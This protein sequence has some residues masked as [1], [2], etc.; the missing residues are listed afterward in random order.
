[1]ERN[2]NGIRVELVYDRDCP[3]VDRAR[4]MIRAAL[5][6]LGAEV[7]WTEWDREDA[8]T[9]RELRRYGSPTV[10]VYGHDVGC[11]E[12]EDAQSDANSC[13]V[14]MDECGCICGAPSSQLIVD[15]IRGAGVQ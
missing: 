2:N 5:I 6:E 12:N 11:D 4:S 14:Y 3:N 15:A 8:A 1:M 10:L 13:R 7:S 9:P